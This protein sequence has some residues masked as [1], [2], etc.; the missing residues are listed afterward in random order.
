MRRFV[1]L[2]VGLAGCDPLAGKDYV[3]EPM[4]TL[5]GTFDAR[6]VAP[7]DKLGGIALMWQDAVTAG[8]PGVAATA[9]PV[10]IEFPST[11]TVSIPAPPPAGVRFRFR[12]DG[13]ELAEAYVYLVA[14]PNAA[15]LVP[16]GSDRVHALVFAS[17]D[18]V[19]G[20][21]EADYLGG[22]MT[23]GYHLRE[24]AAIDTPGTSQAELIAR[25]QS[26]GDSQ[27]ACASRRAYQLGKIAD[28]D[29]LRIVVQR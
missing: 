5:V 20:T 19:A 3:G 12:D 28:D 18:V 27:E 4:F 7:D 25:C 29:P 10:A 24:F 17:A 14:D 8:G 9:V 13:P 26:H 23:A 22:P 11:F 2:A 1:L 16:R 6:T 21:P 15:Q